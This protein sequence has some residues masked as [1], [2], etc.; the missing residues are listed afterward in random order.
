MDG[1]CFDMSFWSIRSVCGVKPKIVCR[2]K[3]NRRRRMESF[4]Q[5]PLNLAIVSGK[6]LT[7]SNADVHPEI[8]CRIPNTGNKSK[9]LSAEKCLL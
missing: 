6:K 4:S 9:N 5:T 8:K 3:E 7:L 2:G 1:F